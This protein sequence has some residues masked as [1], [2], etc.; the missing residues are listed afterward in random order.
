MENNMEN[1]KVVYDVRDLQSILGIGRNLAYD[2]ANSGSFPV[3]R[4]GKRILIS[5]AVFENWLN[6]TENQRAV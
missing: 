5:K 3:R 1:N 4:I 2:L 6:K